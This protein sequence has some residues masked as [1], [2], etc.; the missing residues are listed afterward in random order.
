MSVKLALQVGIDLMKGM[1]LKTSEG[2][3]KVDTMKN[4]NIS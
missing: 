4:T 1:K 2:V 3:I